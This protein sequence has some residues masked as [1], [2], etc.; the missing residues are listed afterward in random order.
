MKKLENLIV[1][2]IRNVYALRLIMPVVYILVLIIL[3]FF[4]PVGKFILIGHEDSLKNAT[5]D[6]SAV[7]RCVEIKLKDLRF[8]G[9]TQTRLSYTS[10]YYYYAMED[11]R[12]YLILL[13]P[14]SS[15][16]GLSII[17]EI[18][19]RAAIKPVAQSVNPVLEGVADDLG[20]SSEGLLRAMCPLMLSEP[21]ISTLAGVL[22]L[23]F[24]AV[25]GIIAL[26]SL[27]N[28]LI[29]M[30]A[31]HMSP[32]ARTLGLFGNR[33]ELLELAT[34]ELATLPQLATEDIYIT[35][36][37]FIAFTR[38]SVTVLPISEIVWIYKHSTLHKF[39]WYH[40][41]IS[42][43]LHIVANK[44]IYVHLPKNMKSDIDGIIDYLAEANH[45]IL[46]GFDEANRQMVQKVMG[47]NR[48]WGAF[49]S[50]MNQRV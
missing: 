37:F 18:V 14:K 8:T 46:V 1:K 4:G 24:Y 15:E 5:S 23:V 43:T 31:P 49:I 40:F 25:T 38:R 9:Y 35:E 10:G 44:H 27:I 16:Q 32:T 39:L 6:A 47:I 36:H 19:I 48:F 41:A 42:Y 2:K 7:N 3:W 11:G 34:E 26:V 28:Y 30:L 45:N 33:R 29:Y 50:L 12:C 13:T 17:D 20:W 22:L 21:D